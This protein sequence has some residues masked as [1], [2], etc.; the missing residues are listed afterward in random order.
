MNV[1]K[2]LEVIAAFDWMPTEE[3]VGILGCD[4]IRGNQIYS[5]EFNK[6]WLRNHRNIILSK[7][8]NNYS[9]I[10][11]MNDAD[12][13]I[14]SC[15]GDALPDRWGRKL[16]DLKSDMGNKNRTF[17]PQKLT[18]WDYL[19][20]IND[21]TRMGGF[22]FINPETGNYINEDKG[23]SIPPLV[24]LNELQE[25]AAHIER[26]L[27]KKLP[28]EEKWINRLF[29]P[30]SSMGGARPKACVLSQDN[31]IYVAKFPSV[32]DEYDVGKW[33]YLANQL[34]KECGIN[35]ADAKLLKPKEGYSIFLSKRF[36]RNSYGQ[37]IHMASSLTMLG[38]KDGAGAETGNGY[39]DI[40]DFIVSGAI[41]SEKQLEE[42]F[43]RVAFN[44]CIGNTDDHFRNHAF[45]LTKDGWILSP[46]YDMNPT[47]SVYQS[48]NINGSSNKSDIN[49]LY[50][51][52]EEYLIGAEKA[53]EIIN[54]VVHTVKYWESMASSLKIN[55]AEQ[56]IIR[57]R[58]DL[59]QEW[60]YGSNMK[61]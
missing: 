61:R 43:R 38:L 15:F 49:L 21:S 46:A 39:L 44:I 55:S 59:C 16:A 26:D 36:D 2:K 47:R 35:T 12:G 9:G 10:Q 22:R 25:A 29:N 3:T 45:V 6:D 30:G 56:R 57:D 40:V 18:D 1:M 41:Q 52:H 27:D 42:L 54:D 58:L 32:K 31:N 37:R 13:Y 51:S 7:D 60:K 50:K 28:P 34:A 17:L 20:A 8:L 14:F 19:Q 24:K 11:Y 23:L 5:F 48:L 33:E 4:N 53:R